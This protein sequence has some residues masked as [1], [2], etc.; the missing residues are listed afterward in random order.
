MRP[1]SLSATRS[2]RV[3]QYTR[4]RDSRVTRQ[5]V[6][7]V[8]LIG[9]SILSTSTSSGRRFCITHSPNWRASAADTLKSTVVLYV[10]CRSCGVTCDIASAGMPRLAASS[11]APTVP[12]IVT[13]LP[14]FSP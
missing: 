11:A 8:A 9:T 7:S 3:G 14:Q 6:C 10:R 4:R 13:P 5:G 2:G 12:E 1:T